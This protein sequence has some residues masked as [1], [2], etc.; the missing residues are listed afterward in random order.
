[1]DK[2]LIY[3]SYDQYEYT[4][5]F[6]LAVNNEVVKYYCPEENVDILFKEIIEKESFAKTFELSVVQ[7]ENASKWDCLE[8]IQE[9]GIEIHPLNDINID[10]LC[11][12]MNSLFDGEYEISGK[13]DVFN[14][15]LIHVLCSGTCFLQ[16][17]NCV[18]DEALKQAEAILKSGGEEMTELARII[19]EKYE[20][21][22]RHD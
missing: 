4:N 12:V 9:H 3:I 22:N 7:D 11:Q 19:K 16:G 17:D 2:V 10:Y 14:K 15:K 1:M 5:Y 6:H 21:M 20:R 13:D 8:A 18:P